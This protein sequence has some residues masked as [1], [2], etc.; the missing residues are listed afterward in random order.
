MLQLNIQQKLAISSI[1]GPVLVVAGPGT[2]KTHVLTLRILEI[3]KRTQANPENILALTFTDAAASN[4]RSRL[5]KQIG[6]D[7]YKINI[8]TFH[9]FCNEIILTNPGTFAF[10]NEN[11][12]ID[13]LRSRKIFESILE[14]ANYNPT[15]EYLRYPEFLNL[16]NIKHELESH[17]FKFKLRSFV[18]PF[19]NINSIKKGVSDIKREFITTDQLRESISQTILEGLDPKIILNSKTGKIKTKYEQLISKIQKNIEFVYCFEKYEEILKAETL[20][21]YDDMINHVALAFSLKD[22]LLAKYQ[23]RYQY[24]LIDEFQDTNGSQNKVVTLLASWD[25]KPNLFVVGDEDQ[26][27]FRFQGAN[28]TN[29]LEFSAR[30]PSASTIVLQTNYRS[31]ANI[32]SASQ[33]LIKRNTERITEAK[34]GKSKILSPADPN[35]LGEK[36]ITREYSKGEI[37]FADIAKQINTLIAK[38]VKPSEIA[39]IFRKNVDIKAMLAYLNYSKIPHIAEHTDGLFEYPYFVNLY[40]Y[41]RAIAEPLSNVNISNLLF[42]ESVNLNQVDLFRIL[43]F[44]RT[45]RQDSLFELLLNHESLNQ[46]ENLQDPVSF[47]NL[48]LKILNLDQKARNTNVSFFLRLMLQDNIAKKMLEQPDRVANLNILKTF[49]D[50]ADARQNEN[51]DYT[52]TDLLRDLQ[53][54]KEGQSFLNIAY[55]SDDPEAIK[56]MTAHKSK[57]LEFEH[58]FIPKMIKGYWGDQRK[59]TNDIKLLIN[60]SDVLEDDKQEEEETRRLI[61][62]AMTRAKNNL[63]LSWSKAYLANPGKYK[64]SLPSKFLSEID[65]EFV[66]PQV[67]STSKELEEIAL[68]SIVSSVKKINLNLE[69]EKYLKQIIEDFKLSATALNN[70]LRNPQEFLERQLLR[71][72]EEKNKSLAL[73]ES[74]HLSLE[75]FFRRLKYYKKIEQLDFM[76]EIFEKRMAKIFGFHREYD[77]TVKEGREILEKWYKASFPDF[78]EPLF[79]EYRFAGHHIML[80]NVRLYGKVDK[81]ELLDSVA[82]T[83]KIIDYKTSKPNS[84]KITESI[85]GD[86]SC[87]IFRQLAFYK[88]LTLCDK[89]FGYS[90]KELEIQ[91]LRPNPRGDFKAVQYNISEKNIEELKTLI[92]ETM[93][94]VRN[95]EF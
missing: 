51:L 83:V 26:S 74:I 24:I 29:M 59:P 37:E 30:Y 27:I 60:D 11:S 94:K 63:Y 45:S 72:P 33:S 49:L 36:I 78:C 88:L 44:F 6:P 84:S 31:C 35:N 54:I 41:L 91:H 90:V 95:L 82:K 62:V 57:G 4:M 47:Q 17:T 25:D 3:L 66:E 64:D 8:S 12:Q 87:D 53:Y 79:I 71:V 20:Y 80:G 61:Y 56:I 85:I 68:E 21:D 89:T 77:E 13:D 48:A 69:S 46:I 81:I 86:T 19:R 7:A 65:S 40:K 28:V 14:G 93:K 18:D 67:I 73:G 2:G 1:E 38:G 23:E 34:Y 9:S 39:V 75:Y 16:L 76:L 15:N 50:F 58:V 32:I 52:L 10:K 55:L 22:D 43:K 5:S 42:L 92:A 70:Y